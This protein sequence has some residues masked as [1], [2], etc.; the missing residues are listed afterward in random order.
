SKREHEA[1]LG[2]DRSVV[3]V[4]AA[5]FWCGQPDVDGRWFLVDASE[6]FRSGKAEGGS[7][8]VFDLRRIEKSQPW[9]TAVRD[10]V[11]L[12]WRPFLRAF[13]E[14]ALAGHEALQAE[15]GELHQA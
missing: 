15:L 8:G 4:V 2:N 14:R 5:L 7:L 3:G 12:M 13:G 9:L 11:G 10:H 6:C 1:L